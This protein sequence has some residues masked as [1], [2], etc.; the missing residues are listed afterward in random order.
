M[1]WVYFPSVIKQGNLA[2]MI[3]DLFK[4]DGRVALVTGARRGLGQGMACGLAQAG[5]D[6][7]CVSRT[8]NAEETRTLVEEAGRKFFDLKVDLSDPNQREGLIDRIA[9]EFAPIDILVNNAGSGDRFPPEDYPQ[10]KW[11]EL[12]EVHLTASFDL[13][14]QA[15]RQM[16]K[17]GRGKIINIGSV[18]TFE[19][20]WHIPA[21]AAAKHGI[22]GLTKSLATAWS[23]KGINVNCIA[24]GYFD[25]DLPGAL[26]ND[27]VRAPQID[28]RIPCGRWGQ[29]EEL[30]GI[31]VFLA[32][33]ASN[34]MHG[35]IVPVDGGWLA[36]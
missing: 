10:E 5:A 6:I 34:Y 2:A 27:P 36:R 22:A 26:R 17:R 33:D 7:A 20:G 35:S 32:S 16:F 14:Q 24:P 23:S 29:P 31:C 18:L 25:T 30:A 8:G 9:S 13:S 1:A 4:L 19:G 15:C 28:D 11:R 12:I 3:L 21:Y